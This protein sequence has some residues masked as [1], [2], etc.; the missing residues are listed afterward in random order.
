MFKIIIRMEKTKKFYKVNQLGSRTSIR[1]ADDS[2]FLRTQTDKL[3]MGKMG[4]V[5]TEEESISGEAS[6]QPFASILASSLVSSRR[7]RKKPPSS[8]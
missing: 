1:M 4:L 2:L 3:M 8:K 5:T 6:L 7:Y